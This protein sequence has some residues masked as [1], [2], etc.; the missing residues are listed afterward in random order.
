MDTASGIDRNLSCTASM[1]Q[2]KVRLPNRYSGGGDALHKFLD[3]AAK[4]GKEAALAEAPEDEREFF[5]G[6]DLD[7]L[8]AG[9]ESEVG[10]AYHVEMG[11][12]RRIPA[13]SDAGG[14][15]DMGQGWLLGSM[16]RVGV[17]IVQDHRV[18]VV[19]DFKR[20]VF[21]RAASESGQL[22]VYA[23]AAA[24]LVGADYAEVLFLRPVASGWVTDRAQLDAMALDD[25]ADRLRELW[26][27]EQEARALYLERGPVG[28]LEAGLVIPGAQCE[29]CDCR[30]ACPATTAMLRAASAGDIAGLASVAAGLSEEN[31]I[32]AF[33]ALALPRFEA[34]E[35]ADVGVAY[36]RLRVLSAFVEG[37]KKA[38]DEI[39]ARAPVPLSGGKVRVQGTTTRW[40]KSDRAKEEIAA[41]TERLKVAREIRSVTV[42]QMRTV[43]AP[44]PKRPRAPRQSL[45]SALESIQI[46]DG[47]GFEQ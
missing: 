25:F 2:P 32:E 26:R 7:A 6:I 41:L 33:K 35:L 47:D 15:P 45:A 24:R 18:A 37:A 44:K 19:A 36:E 10:L 5:G 42:P 4:H 14:Y 3:A 11:E 21:R 31:A 38:C 39:A 12:V 30:L 28:L 17:R 20:Y 27:S 8:P 9:M 23:L 34:L 40:E 29:F 43:N 16:D 46:P 13:R 22:A 1:V